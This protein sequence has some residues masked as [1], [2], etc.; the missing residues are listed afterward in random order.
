MVSIVQGFTGSIAELKSTMV[1][2]QDAVEKSLEGNKD[3]LG[4]LKKTV[5]LVESQRIDQQN[6]INTTNA[7]VNKVDLHAEQL[8]KWTPETIK[9]AKSIAEISFE[10]SSATERH[11]QQFK[12]VHEN[13]LEKV[14][15][16]LESVTGE[17]SKQ[18]TSSTNK[19]LMEVGNSVKNIKTEIQ[20]DIRNFEQDFQD[21]NVYLQEENKKLFETVNASLGN[22][23]KSFKDLTNAT[24]ESIQVSV[25]DG[26]QK[27]NDLIIESHKKQEELNQNLLIGVEDLITSPKNKNASNNARGSV[28]QKGKNNNGN[29]KS[30]HGGNGNTDPLKK[31]EYEEKIDNSTKSADNDIANNE[32]NDPGKSVSEVVQKIN[33][34]TVQILKPEPEKEVIELPK[35]T[36]VK[37]LPIPIEP[38]VS[39]IENNHSDNKGWKNYWPFNKGRGRK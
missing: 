9:M 31:E 15:A 3:T 34:E 17:M 22:I 6:L 26:Y 12:E 38:K 28:D 11:I 21:R 20:E 19:F 35:E 24:I 30:Y 36:V 27:L 16:K 37:P 4:A 29:G 25:G 33:E 10:M 13:T 8:N 5:E 39:V 32:L 23:T 7:L 18:V 2:M 14:S 1:A